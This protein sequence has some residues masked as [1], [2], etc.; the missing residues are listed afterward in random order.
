MGGA[1]GSPANCPGVLGVAGLRNQGDKV[2]YSSY[3]KEVGISAPAG[4]CINTAV[5]Q[6]C[7]FPMYTTTNFGLKGPAG[8]GMT[9]EF[10]YTVGTSFSAPLVSAAVALM[11]D[12]NPA[13]T[14]TETIAKINVADL[15]PCNCS[16]AICGSGMLD[17]L[18]ALRLAAP[19]SAGHTRDWLVVEFQRKRNCLF[20]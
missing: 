14:P 15:N 12:L 16:S 17:A 10:N 1:V 11:I 8:P 9:D 3:G 7:L 19:P 2:G 6:P 5:N 4:N 20:C 18:S 13:L